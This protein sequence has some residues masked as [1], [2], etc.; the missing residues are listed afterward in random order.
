MNKKT[1]NLINRAAQGKSPND[2]KALKCL[3]RLT[4]KPERKFLRAQLL[5]MA[6]K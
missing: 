5:E 3:W 4:P 6:R 2:L 1:T